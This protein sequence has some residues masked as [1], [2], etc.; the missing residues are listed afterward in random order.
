MLNFTGS[1]KVFVATGVTDLRK[2]FDGLWAIAANALKEDPSQGSLF[3]FSNRKRNRIKILYCDGSGVWVMAK[4]LDEGTFSW[5][6]G[7]G[8]ENGKLNLT[9]EALSLLIDGV[10]LKRGSLRP[11]YQ[12]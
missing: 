3:V 2:S 5:P 1:L 12:R 7:V 9:P 10:D 8:G 11:W 6:A 4:R